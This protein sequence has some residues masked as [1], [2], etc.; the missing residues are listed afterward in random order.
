[1]AKSIMVTEKGKC[2]L[3]GKSCRTEKHHVFEG[4][5]R[6]KLSEDYGLWVYLCHWCH[7][8]PPDGVHFNKT[9]DLDLKAQAQRIAMKNYSWTVE[10]F[11]KRFRRNYI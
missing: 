1:M 11:R 5:G 3:C 4:S 2:F 8:E 10:Q 6:R 9:R 7:N